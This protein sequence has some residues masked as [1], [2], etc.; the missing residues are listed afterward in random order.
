MTVEILETQIRWL[1]KYLCCQ[2]DWPSMN[3]YRVCIRCMKTVI[4]AMPIEQEEV[5]LNDSR[6]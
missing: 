4:P 5:D 2:C 6:F 1:Y 3:K